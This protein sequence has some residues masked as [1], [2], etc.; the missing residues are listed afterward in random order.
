M[1]PGLR[2]VYGAYARAAGELPGLPGALQ[3]EVWTSAQ[4][5]ALEAAAP[6]EQ[7]RRAALADLVTVLR[8]A[9]TPGAR[10][11]LLVLAAIGPAGLRRIAARAAAD[12]RGRPEPP[13]AGALGEVTPGQA[14]L[15]QEGPL[16]GDR[17]VC[18]F[19]YPGGAG[20]HALAVRLSYGDVPAEI[21]VVGDV[22]A[23][24]AAARQAMQAELCVVQP[25]DAAAAGARLRAALERAEALPEDCYPALAL[26]R[27][28]AAVL[29]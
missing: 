2:E 11:F 17:L 28:R 19:R 10:A 22:P 29:P 24:M 27:H 26:A 15:I 25:C 12:L 4:L 9:G 3:A 18:E 21:V 5:G 20:L 14:W 16:D 8:E 1:L 6:H 7:G 23:M 13:W